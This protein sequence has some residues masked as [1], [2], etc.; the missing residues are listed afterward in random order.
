MPWRFRWSQTACV[1]ASTCAS[2]NEQASEDPRWPLVPKLT[3]WLGSAGS[4]LSW[5]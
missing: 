3:R 4:G 5:K 1:I 2:L